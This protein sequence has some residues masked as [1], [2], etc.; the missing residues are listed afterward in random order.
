MESLNEVT[1]ESEIELLS[2]V[3][4]EIDSIL[5]NELDVLSD[6]LMKGT[7]YLDK[8]VHPLELATYER[9]VLLLL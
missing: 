7:S 6:E 5:D 8:V 4:S 1:T 2:E 3:D 9:K